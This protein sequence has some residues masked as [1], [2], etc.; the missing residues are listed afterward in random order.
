MS[1]KD[2]PIPGNSHGLGSLPKRANVGEK[3]I[4]FISKCYNE[5]NSKEWPEILQYCKERILEAQLPH[6]VVAL[7][8]QSPLASRLIT[9]MKN[10]LKKMLAS[11][12]EPIDSMKYAEKKTPSQR[13][14]A[15][16]DK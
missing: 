4:E 13:R 6:H 1:Q 10:I 2:S 12:T 15:V 11:P 3:E 16:K 8:L 5:C 9:K 14:Q 7:Y